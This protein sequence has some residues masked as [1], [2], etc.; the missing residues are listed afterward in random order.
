MGA[1]FG[2]ILVVLLMGLIF[3]PRAFAQE[4]NL[5]TESVNNQVSESPSQEEIE[6]FA[7]ALEGYDVVNYFHSSTS[8]KGNETYQAVYQGKRY[9]FVS[10]KNRAKFA[11]A[12]E[13]YLPEFEEYCGC[14]VSENKHVKADPAVFK[15]TEGKLVLFKDQKAL[16]K[17]NENEGKRYEDAQKFWKYESEYNAN[18]RLNDDTRVRLFSF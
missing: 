17:W 4:H 7:I 12:P 5:P 14:A 13:D 8:Q 1:L 10:A 18:K 9:L 6:K 11:V 3:S 2:K 15:I 16:S